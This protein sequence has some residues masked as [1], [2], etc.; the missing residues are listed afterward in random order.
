MDNGEY[1]VGVA[2]SDPYGVYLPSRYF[3]EL[4]LNA[5]DPIKLV[6][7][8]KGEEKEIVAKA[9]E[10]DVFNDP[11]SAIHPF[12][13]KELH[14]LFYGVA[15]II[16][17][18]PEEFEDAFGRFQGEQPN[19]IEIDE[20]EELADYLEELTANVVRFDE[21]QI[22]VG[23]GFFE[24][25]LKDVRA[26][27]HEQTV[28]TPLFQIDKPTFKE[29]LNLQ[30]PQLTHLEPYDKEIGRPEPVYFCTEY[31]EATDKQKKHLSEKIAEQ[32]LFH[33]TGDY[34]LPHHY[35]TAHGPLPTDHLGEQP[36]VIEITP[37]AIEFTAAQ[38]G[39][40]HPVDDD[41]ELDFDQ[42]APV[43]KNLFDQE[44]TTTQISREHDRIAFHID[45]IRLTFY[46]LEDQLHYSYLHIIDQDTI[47]AIEEAL[48]TLPDHLQNELSIQAVK[49]PTGT[50]ELVGNVDRETWVLDTS[51]LYHE[52]PGRGPSSLMHFLLPNTNLYGKRIKVPWQ[53]LAEIN[54]HKDEGTALQ[55]ASEQGVENLRILRLLQNYEFLELDIGEV[56][57]DLDTSIMPET[58]ATDLAILAATR[59]ADDA[60]LLTRDEL[61]INLCKVSETPVEHIEFLTTLQPEE[62][63]RDLFEEVEQE[64]LEP[65]KRDKL[66]DRIGDRLRM[67]AETRDF[68]SHPTEEGFNENAR[69]MLDNWL[70]ERFVIT[71]P[72]KGTFYVAQSTVVDVVPSF[73]L[74]KEIPKYIESEDGKYLNRTFIEAMQRAARLSS[75]VFPWVHFHIPEEFVHTAMEETAKRD[76]DGILITL[77][78]LEQLENAD[79][80]SLPLITEEDNPNLEKIA[81]RAAKESESRLICLEDE[82]V[83]RLARLLEAPIG[84]IKLN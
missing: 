12:L 82:A 18:L 75:N 70:N 47:D 77:Y 8:V 24:L 52:I 30:L 2:Y 36:D 40:I 58:G 41:A 25:F 53:V 62:D 16:D 81:V 21:D 64:L 76:E 10:Q 15:R 42:I 38:F 51:A 63:E 59:E 79:Y 78:Q 27:E 5:G 50:K 29:L 28:K 44:T 19:E 60:V 22:I 43:L 66:V 74:L 71:Y 32:E 26:T 17:E 1:N 48:T 45:N 65:Q 83:T 7:Q 67:K 55:T 3:D 37:E 68:P 46:I 31:F 69:D 33:K 35:I 84:R 11:E 23:C 61:L 4:G 49:L 72:V 14:A 56:P 73:N 20:L 34:I 9:Q 39:Q 80:S 57:G 6:F 54:R 13:K